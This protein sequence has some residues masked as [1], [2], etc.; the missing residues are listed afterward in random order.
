MLFSFLDSYRQQI[1]PLPAPGAR[2]EVMGS[3]WAT[4]E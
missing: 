4:R 2:Q 1:A 3:V